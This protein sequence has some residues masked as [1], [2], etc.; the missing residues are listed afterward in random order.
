MHISLLPTQPEAHFWPILISF[1]TAIE[2]FMNHIFTFYLFP[3]SLDDPLPVSLVHID[4]VS[5]L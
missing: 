2:G 1:G 5:L 4:Q 3:F